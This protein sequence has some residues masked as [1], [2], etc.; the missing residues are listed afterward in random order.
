MLIVSVKYLHIVGRLSGF[1]DVSVVKY[2]LF[3]DLIVEEGASCMHQ[4]NSTLLSR[5]CSL[6]SGCHYGQVFKTAEFL[7]SDYYGRSHW[8]ET[9]GDARWGCLALLKS[10]ISLL[11]LK[12]IG[13][14]V[15]DTHVSDLFGGKVDYDVFTLA[16]SDRNLISADIPLDHRVIEM[17]A[18]FHCGIGTVQALEDKSDLVYD[19]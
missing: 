11:H 6:S 14:G 3:A 4:F 7:I 15:E 10:E 19:G 17:H 8:V 2:N 12:S 16:V 18:C 5:G 13:I 9:A 1:S